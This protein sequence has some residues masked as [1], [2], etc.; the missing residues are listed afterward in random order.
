MVLASHYDSSKNDILRNAMVGI[1]L[2]LLEYHQGVLF[3][4]TNRV[5]CLDEV[6]LIFF[7]F[8]FFFVVGENFVAQF[9]RLS[10]LVSTLRCS[11]RLSI[12]IRAEKS[13]RTFCWSRART[14]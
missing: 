3:L 6:G 10:R 4:T 11:I 2:R 1:F 9:G 5:E 12:A 14:D 8:F 7:F 13:G